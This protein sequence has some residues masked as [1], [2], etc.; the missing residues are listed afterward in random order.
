MR[1]TAGQLSDRLH[2]LGLAEPQ[3]QIALLGRVDEIG[4]A[5]SLAAG[6]VD[7]DEPEG[8]RF[9]RGQSDGKG[10]RRTLSR[11]A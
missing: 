1:N 9:L 4:E 8:S 10:L 3:F 6:C 11:V 7:G 2:F 5:V